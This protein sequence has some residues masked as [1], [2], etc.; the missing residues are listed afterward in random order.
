VLVR[1]ER[2]HEVGKGRRLLGDEG[3][4]QRVEREALGA[5][6]SRHER[7]TCRDRVEELEL[8]SRAEPHRAHVDSRARQPFGWVL[9]IA[10]DVDPLAVQCLD[11]RS[12]VGADHVQT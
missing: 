10:D 3:W 6:R 5:D 9:H 1:V 4:A 2:V 11:R 12:R 7:L 8:D